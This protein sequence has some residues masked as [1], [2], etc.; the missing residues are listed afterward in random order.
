M[1]LY[2]TWG[3][4]HAWLIDPAA[5]TLE[6]LRLEGGRWV[7]LAAHG[8]SARVRAEPFEAVEIELARL[9]GGG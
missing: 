7:V 8:D 9:W 4:P 3:V 2:A 1:P 6:V 5:R